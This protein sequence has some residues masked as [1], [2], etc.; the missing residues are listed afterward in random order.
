MVNI[1]RLIDFFLI[2]LTNTVIFSIYLLLLSDF[3]L[4]FG[5]VI[6]FLLISIVD[7]KLVKNSYEFL[8]Y[9]IIR[10]LVILIAIFVFYHFYYLVNNGEVRFFD[11]YNYKDSYMYV[12]YADKIYLSDYTVLTAFNE[13]PFKYF[14]VSFFYYAVMVSFDTQ[15]LIVLVFANAVLYSYL[16]FFISF[17]LEKYNCK[18]NK[19]IISLILLI[20][21]G[22]LYWTATLSREVFYFI[23]LAMVFYLVINYKSLALFKF[24]YFGLSALGS[25]SSREILLPAFT[26]MSIF[27]RFNSGTRL[28]FIVNLC[29]IYFLLTLFFVSV[30]YFM[31][32]LFGYDYYSS[33]IY[34]PG[35][36]DFIDQRTSY[37]PFD[38]GET[39][40]LGLSSLFFTVFSEVNIFN[41]ISPDSIDYANLFNSLNGIARLSFF[42]LI[43]ILFV[44]FGLMRFSYFLLSILFVFYL[45]NSLSIGF[46][47]ARYI[48][49]GDFFVFTILL[50]EIRRIVRSY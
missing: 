19:F 20:N 11:E 45:I 41:Y 3:Y 31:K 37:K 48:L 25:I 6:V 28:K 46:F 17:L 4:T 40:Y 22:M 10:L 49:F 7:F 1:N 26:F 32:V 2:F 43:F 29:M 27:S 35:H 15:D 42:G 30:V 34:F 13:L 47:Q 50:F 23:F 33:S 24:K 5:L 39:F 44:F 18:R 9:S 38:V 16:F 12:Y 8:V 36:V 21:P 14:F